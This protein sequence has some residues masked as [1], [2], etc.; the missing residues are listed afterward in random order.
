MLRDLIDLVREQQT[1]N[2]KIIES[3]M[4]AHATQAAVFQSWLEM[5]KPSAQ[6]ES[7][8]TPDQRALIR[9]AR[10]VE[11]WDPMMARMAHDLMKDLP[12]A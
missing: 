10:E 1:H 2:T 12:N 5:F 6:P 3:M 11:E 4:A 9:E 7:S 8:T